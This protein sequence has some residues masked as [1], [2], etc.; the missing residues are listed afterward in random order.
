[1]PPPPTNHADDA[2]PSEQEQEQHAENSAELIP[3]GAALSAASEAGLST[4]LEQAHRDAAANRAQAR[5]L[6]RTLE[7]VR[8]SHEYLGKS[9]RK[10]QRRSRYLVYAA[11]LAPILAAALVWAI[12]NRTDGVR[13]EIDGRLTAVLDSQAELQRGQQ[14]LE[15]R[16]VA[17]AFAVRLKSL[18]EELARSRSD[19]S[20]SR[21]ELTET[22]DA[23]G[24]QRSGA[25]E[26]EAALRTRLG[27]LEDG[28]AE[29]AAL[30]A[31]VDTLRTRAGAETARGDEL[32]REI[33][34]L[35]SQLGAARSRLSSGAA[36]VPS[37]SSPDA[38]RRTGR[39]PEGSGRV[40]AGATGD[41]ATAALPRPADGAARN[42]RDTGRI[43]DELNRLLDLS[44]GAVGY[45]VDSLGGVEGDRLLDVAITGRDAAGRAIRTLQAKQATFTVEESASQ[46]TVLLED[47]HLL[48]GGHKAPFFGGRYSLVVEATPDAWRTSSLSCLR[49][50]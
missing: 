38:G 37:T 11:M 17:E 29:L 4:W 8:E 32:E 33:R 39:M 23:M 43:K 47:G 19:V 18:E 48:L 45:T 24:D 28:Q 30:R 44:A 46:V 50:D 26:R 22:R 12:W 5:E 2:P 21:D 15:R 13:Q 7:R 41:P 40:A 16:D 34:A 14:E 6:S 31:Q 25:A 35:E 20:A 1:M 42:P 49:F 27:A 10:E 9:L 36:G 3:A